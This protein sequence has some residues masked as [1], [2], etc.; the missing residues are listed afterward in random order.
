VGLCLGGGTGVLAKKVT[1]CRCVCFGMQSHAEKAASRLTD[2][3]HSHRMLCTRMKARD[4]EGYRGAE[5]KW[6]AIY[7]VFLVRPSVH[8][9]QV[10]N[11]TSFFDKTRNFRPTLIPNSVESFSL[12][13]SLND[14]WH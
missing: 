5:C 12:K 4:E 9:E 14:I 2:A 8:M 3:C 13:F 11:D 10:Q 1:D 6:R 7:W